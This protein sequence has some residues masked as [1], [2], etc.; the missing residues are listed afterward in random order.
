[1]LISEEIEISVWDSEVPRRR[2]LSVT[3]R[4]KLL[5]SDWRRNIT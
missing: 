1:M 4:V 3:K 5:G 2:E